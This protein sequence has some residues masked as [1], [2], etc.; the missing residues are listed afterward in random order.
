MRT[1][2]LAVLLLSPLLTARAQYVV[3]AQE[4]YGA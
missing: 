4:G 3:T 1:L 2:V